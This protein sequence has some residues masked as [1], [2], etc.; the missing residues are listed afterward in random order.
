ILTHSVGT[1]SILNP[2]RHFALQQYKIKTAAEQ[3]TDDDGDGNQGVPNIEI[4]HVVSS[5]TPCS[6][7]SLARGA[8]YGISRAS[9]ARREG[10]CTRPRRSSKSRN[11]W[12]S[13]LT[14]SGGRTAQWMAW[15]RP[16][17]LTNVPSFSA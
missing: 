6:P 4:A 17:W 12:P 8:K 16:A 15:A 13:G 14:P 2:G 11:T 9:S 5:N 7:G 1:Q 10:A 3:H